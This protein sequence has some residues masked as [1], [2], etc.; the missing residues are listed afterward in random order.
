M[1][2]V[3]YPES[4]GAYRRARREARVNGELVTQERLAEAVGIKRR[5]II[6]VENGEN[7]PRP[8]L[9]DLIANALGVDPRT[10]PAAGEDPFVPCVVKTTH[11]FAG[12]VTK[13]S[14]WFQRRLA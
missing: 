11:S 12:F 13:F 3:R 1:G 6:R 7:R 5:F 8:A 4:G 10:L 2:T 14:A 9:R